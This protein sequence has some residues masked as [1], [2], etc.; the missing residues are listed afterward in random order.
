M[1]PS[2]LHL[3]LRRWQ[4]AGP[5]EPGCSHTWTAAGFPRLA[6]WLRLLLLPGLLWPLP[7]LLLLLEAEP[8]P[9]EKAA[10]TGL[11]VAPLQGCWWRR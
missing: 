3:P 2:P 11:V 5:R 1:D 7:Q 4:P 8:G 6:V 9:P 10:A